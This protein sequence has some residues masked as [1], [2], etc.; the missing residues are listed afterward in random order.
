MKTIYNIILLAL[1]ALFLLAGC[2][3]QSRVNK[4]KQVVL[5]DAQ[6]RHEIFLR[7][8]ELYPCSNDSIVQTFS[9]QIDSVTLA[10]Y[11][12][13]FKAHVLK[14]KVSLDTLPKILKDAY[15]LGYKDASDKYL[16][17]KVPKCNPTFVKVTVKDKQKEKILGDSLVAR[18]AMIGARDAEIFV[19]NNE[20]DRMR[21]DAKAASNKW[22]W[23][24]ILAVVIG[25]ISNAAWAYFKIFKL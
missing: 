25:L 15:E 13:N 21:E 10:E 11:L 4:A 20:I 18:N 1:T 9:G 19:L 12:S 3:Y 24:F 17:V 8:L 6:A 7:E 22:V 5:M 16:A 2:N 23:R 14:N